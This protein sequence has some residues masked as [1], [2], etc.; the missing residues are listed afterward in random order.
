M[1][2]D[3]PLC[4]ELWNVTNRAGIVTEHRIGSHSRGEEEERERC[5][6]WHILCSK[7]RQLSPSIDTAN[8]SQKSELILGKVHKISNFSLYLK[9]F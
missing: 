4:M 6:L 8:P 3:T 9:T 7:Y 5:V 2:C 1:P